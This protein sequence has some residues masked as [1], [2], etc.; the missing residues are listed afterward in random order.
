MNTIFFDKIADLLTNILAITNNSILLTADFNCPG[1]D[2]D[3]ID[4]RF[5]AMLELFGMVQTDSGLTRRKSLLDILA[6]NEEESFVNN[7]RLDDAGCVSAHRT[8]LAQLALGWRRLMQVTFSFRR[9]RQLN[10][11]FFENSLRGSSLFTNSATSPNDF[12]DQLA[13]VLT[14]ELDKVALKTVTRTS[15]EK[16]INQFLYD[17][18]VKAKK[19]R[20]RLERC[21]K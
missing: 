18:A 2:S 8:V 7:V 3:T 4:A 10:F 13:E 5:T 9:L 21:W 15:T 12:A 20:W 17:A 16:Q 19:E 14:S 6:D 11:N 1:K